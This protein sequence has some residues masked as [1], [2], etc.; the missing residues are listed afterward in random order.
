MTDKIDAPAAPDKSA[1]AA[2]RS[3]QDEKHGLGAML[4]RVLR[5]P[6]MTTLIVIGLGTWLIPSWLQRS[7]VRQSELTVKSGIV[8]QIASDTTTS[9]R[10]AI[11]RA[12]PGAPKVSND[13][14]KSIYFTAVQQWLVERAL[15]RAKFATYFPDLEPAWYTYSDVVT[16]YLS[17]PQP[18]VASAGY[19]DQIKSYVTT[20]DASECG[21]GSSQELRHRAFLQ[22][23]REVQ[24]ERTQQ[25]ETARP[26]QRVRE[27]R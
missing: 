25:P 16:S 26:R 1:D 8:D 27:P 13:A 2:D 4:A 17:I 24:L 22:P 6:L 20:T 21:P 15:I 7:Q 23:S 3:D 19:V 11:T 10:A 18:D 9:V 14:L 5:H 12:S